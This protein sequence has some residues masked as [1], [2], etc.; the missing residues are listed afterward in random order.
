MGETDPSKG[1]KRPAAVLTALHGRRWWQLGS[2][3]AAGTIFGF[4]LQKGGLT[5]YDV[6][7][8]QLLLADFTVARVM[9]TAIVT[10][11]VGIH[12]LRSLGLAVHHPK[13]GSWGA[14]GIG[15]L[16]FGAGFGLLGYCPGTLA[17]AVGTGA[18]DALLGGMPGLLV[19]TWLFARLY[20][21]LEGTILKRGYFG[22]L[23]FPQLWG[24]N[25]WTAV[26]PVCFA[27]L[28][29]LFGWERA[30]L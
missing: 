1:I 18:L 26:I 21:R 5:D 2:G 9:I 22:P 8:G 29:L 16:I 12:L 13:E 19:G 25:P 23:T 20:P 15:G 14:V 28:L 30:G 27:L 4:L 3:L 11:M 10:G 7:S 17:G 24:V 6:L